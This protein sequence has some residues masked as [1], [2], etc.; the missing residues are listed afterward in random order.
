M[1]EAQ[2]LKDG[3]A[4]G[5]W[6]THCPFCQSPVV[7]TGTAAIRCPSC[8]RKVRPAGIRTAAM[9]TSTR[10]HSDPLDSLVGTKLGQWLLVRLIGKGGMGRV[11]EAEDT[12]SRSKRRVALK[13]LDEQL[14]GDPAFVKRFR[15]EARVLSNL[16][17]PHVV[18]VLAQ[19]EDQG[20]V[21]FAMAYVRGENLRT[22]IE[23]GALS[24]AEAA[25]IATEV[26][27][28]LAY[29]HDRGVIH[30]DL[31][32][33]NVLLDERG[34]VHL[35]DFGLSRLMA[36][37]TAEASTRLTRTDVIMGTYEYMSPEQRRGDRALDAR[38]DIF[39][40]GV[41]LYEMLTGTL[42]LGRFALPSERDAG[43]PA[44]IDAVVTKALATDR[45]DRFASAAELQ[46]ALTQAL[47]S[48]PRSSISAAPS[49]PTAHAIA[50]ARKIM[51]HVDIMSAIDKVAGFLLL[52]GGLGWISLS[53]LFDIGPVSPVIH[54]GGFVALVFGIWLMNQGGKLSELKKGSRESQ[55]TASAI[56]LLFPPFLTAAGI[57]GLVI[58]TSDRARHAF[59]LGRKRLRPDATETVVVTKPAQPVQ[60]HPRA[61]SLVM[62]LFHFCAV[63]WSLYAGFVAVELFM[64]DAGSL[65]VIETMAH[66]QSVRDISMFASAFAFIVMLQAFFNR[67]SRRGVGLAVIAFLF[68]MTATALVLAGVE[69]AGIHTPAGFRYAIG[70]L[71]IDAP[72]ISDALPRLLESAQ[73]LTLPPLPEIPA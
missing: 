10:T 66:G 45:R 50:D 20:R 44:G 57:Y 36:T 69:D 68:L 3:P 47:K 16:S 31:K 41:I 22:R 72:W 28:A 39:S 54:I 37:G 60:F 62:R 70:A 11:Y 6:T 25:R 63:L 13:V 71:S 26:G 52:A 2:T 43:I 33:E 24:A 34:H 18:Q 4:T 40:L 58:M 29:A 17:H 12:E 53:K 7:V 5:R 1:Q 38:A 23:R 51:R 48:A 55:I 61:A 49:A 8:R 42:P 67:K 9:R 35:V 14:A 65:G 30:R 15:R 64:L 73:S 32:P 56:M 27:S 19:G 46:D 21:W 59:E